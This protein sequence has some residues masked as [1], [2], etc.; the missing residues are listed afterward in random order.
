MP[1]QHGEGKV[2][3]HSTHCLRPSLPSSL[4]ALPLPCLRVEVDGAVVLADP[5]E[6]VRQPLQIRHLP[7]ADHTTTTADPQMVNPQGS[8]QERSEVHRRADTKW[9][10]SQ[11]W[12]AV[13]HIWPLP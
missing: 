9:L 12:V 7:H 6:V 5:E 10:S 4:P 8:C 3:G 11:W 13:T 1:I 2:V